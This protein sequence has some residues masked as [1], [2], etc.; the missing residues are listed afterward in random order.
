MHLWE[1]FPNRSRPCGCATFPTCVRFA[2]SSSSSCPG[3]SELLSCESGTIRVL[4]SRI[5]NGGLSRL[6]DYNK[7]GST[8]RKSNG[9]LPTPSP[10][11]LVTPGTSGMTLV[12]TKRIL[13]WKGSVHSTG[14]AKGA[15]IEEAIT[16]DQSTTVKL[17]PLPRLQS[18]LQGRHSDESKQERLVWACLRTLIPGQ[19]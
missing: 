8:V 2:S 11:I 16:K 9:Q 18:F 1:T 13:P 15:K 3:W 4:R 7:K 12:V 10:S 14:D 17:K 19:E 5:H 6:L